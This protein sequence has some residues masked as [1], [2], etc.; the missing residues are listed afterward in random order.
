MKRYERHSAHILRTARWKALRFQ[1]LERDGFACVKCG[2]RGR[3]EVDHIQPVKAR[4]DLAYEPGNLQSLCPRCHGAKTRL[5]LGFPEL[6]PAR[7]A[8][9]DLIKKPIEQ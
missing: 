3:L 8:W 2:A 1:I 7:Q 6:S 9:R 5:E 4:P